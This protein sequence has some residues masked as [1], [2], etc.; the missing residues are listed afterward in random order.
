MGGNASTN[1]YKSKTQ[2]NQEAVSKCGT[3]ANQT[4]NVKNVS[5]KCPE[6]CVVNK[7]K[8]DVNI[9]NSQTVD[10]KCVIGTQQDSLA[11]LIASLGADSQAGLGF[12]ASTNKVDIQKQIEQKI[13][14]ECQNKSDQNINI[15]E[16]QIETCGAITFLNNA[17]VKTQCELGAVQKLVEKT[18][19]EVKATTKGWDPTA[20]LTGTMAIYAVVFIVIV[21]VAYFAFGQF[22]KSGKS[23]KGLMGFGRRYKR[24][25]PQWAFKKRH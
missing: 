23:I 8:C 16:T 25:V 15:S 12:S 4:I 5:I 19:T 1:L 3:T 11:A 20:L 21:I 6:Y 2:L 7:I 17:T 22:L 13:S 24:R 10:A 18:E 9:G 14:N